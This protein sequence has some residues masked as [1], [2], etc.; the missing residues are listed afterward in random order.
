MPNLKQCLLICLAFLACAAT[1]FAAET[2][3]VPMT[4]D[5]WRTDTG[6]FEKIQGVDAIALRQGM[7]LAKGITLRNGTIEFD[8]QPFAMGTGLAFRRRDDNSYEYFY[9]R[10]NGKC[11]QS[12]DCLQYAPETHGVLLWDVFPQ[13][14][15]AASIRDGEW[16]HIKIV[17]SGQRMNLYVNREKTP[18]LKIGRLEGDSAEGGISLQG[19][20]YFAN[21]TFTPDATEGLSADPAPDPTASD[22]HFI[23]DWQVSPLSELPTGKDP[24]IADM[25][26]LSAA[27]QPLAA[28][29]GGLVNISRLYGLPLER[30][31]RSLAWIRTSITSDKSQSIKTSIGWV[32]EV[33]VFVNGQLV[34]SDKNLYM[35]ATARKTPDG[36]CSLE[37]GSFQ[38]PLNAGSNEVAI[39]VATNFYGLAVILR[40]DDVTGLQLA[41]K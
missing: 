14:Q 10:P 17:L 25:P 24:S 8:V 15:A 28:E 35:P 9:I 27:W 11:A 13:Y 18:S 38:L 39:A 34:Y 31:R 19:P 2:T 4:A 32:R 3:K 37:N 5:H 21:F 12:E 29:R 41:R 22:A 26:A 40:P 6:V 7:A 33:W 20:G 1:A 30:P 23:R 36:R 16:N